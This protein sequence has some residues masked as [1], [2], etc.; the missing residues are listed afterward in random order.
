MSTEDAPPP[1]LAA[2]GTAPVH[3]GTAAGRWILLATVLGSGMAALDATVVNVALPAMG[4][5][6]DAGVA[7]LQWILNGYLLALAS[8]I[9]L[10]GS[11]GDRFGRKRVFVIGVVWFA[12]ASLLCGLAPSVELLVAARVL[13]GVGGALLTPG[14]LA[15]IQA[16]F[17]P[18]D[19]GRAIGA[20]SALGGV[21]TAAGPFFGGWLVDA[22]SWR[23]IFLL[24]LPL[25]VVVVVVALAHV[26]ETYDPT[27]ARRLDLAG[28]SSAPSAWRGSPTPSSRA[29]AK[30][31]RRP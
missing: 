2:A 8:L 23:W 5:D 4:E 11:L 30:A 13:Q 29:P 27:M 31:G 19:R 3:F 7:G 9:L 15:I 6:L 1:S 18:E 16:S 10:G 17:A 26:P 12:L 28:A 21:A 24:N 25:A 14:S 20:W 22:A